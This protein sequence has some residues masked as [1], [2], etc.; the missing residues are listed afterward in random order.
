ML[1]GCLPENDRKMKGSLPI[2]N[3]MTRLMICL[4]FL[5]VT[6][7]LH[8]QE[9]RTW[10]A[11]GG[12]TTEAVFVSYTGGMVKLRQADGNVIS[13]PI[14]RL[15]PV[16]RQLAIELGSRN[17]VGLMPNEPLEKPTGRREL[18]WKKIERGVTWPDSLNP[19]EFDVIQSM[20]GKW[21]HAETKYAVIHFQSQTFARKVGRVA[22]FQYAYIATD[23]QGLQ[24]LSR[25]KSHIIV[26][27]DHADWHRFLR[28]SGTAP[29]WAGAFV[30]GDAMFMF[31]TDDETVNMNILAHEMSHLVLNRFFHRRFPLWLNEGLAEWY[32][33]TGYR[34]FHGKRERRD[35]AFGVMARPIPVAELLALNDYTTDQTRFY[36]SSQSLVGMLQMRGTPDQFIALLKAIGVEGKEFLTALNEVYGIAS[37]EELTEAFTAFSRRQ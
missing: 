1:V 22:D 32:A 30:R 23:L 13:V 6:W 10:S 29:L 26:F 4:L 37:V 28:D 3:R 11:V 17:A 2:N 15:D 12:Y 20:D 34:S 35:E 31:D 5:C 21:Q 19:A 25:K 24:D 8:A 16:D 14:G 36:A 7:L 9:M 18:T 27:S 33:F